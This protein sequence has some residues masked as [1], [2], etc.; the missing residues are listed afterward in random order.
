MLHQSTKVKFNNGKDANRALV[1][2]L[3]INFFTHGKLETTITKAKV[4]KTTV[5]RLVQKAK[6]ESEANKNV[7]LSA[8]AD[9][10]LI[11]RMFSEIGPSMK[12]IQGGYVRIS[13]LN[14]RD[15]DG[16]LMAKVTWAHPLTTKVEEVVEAKATKEVIEKEQKP[17]KRVTKKKETDTN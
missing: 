4:L 15:S 13:R 16:A 8:L 5:E 2:K 14:Q 11:A 1:R 10:K 7:L 3:A 17:K 12:D 6:V 9:K